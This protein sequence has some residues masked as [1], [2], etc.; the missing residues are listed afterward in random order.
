MPEE[1]ERFLPKLLGEI[2]L[3][4]SKLMWNVVVATASRG[5]F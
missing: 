4:K 3:I 1:D 2:S 5:N